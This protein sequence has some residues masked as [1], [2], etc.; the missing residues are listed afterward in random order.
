[1]DPNGPFGAKEAGEGSMTSFLP[2]LANAVYRATGVRMKELP[3]TPD[4]LLA[5]QGK[6]EKQ[7]A[8]DAAAGGA[9]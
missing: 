7:Q 9:E 1:M 4:R 5:A 2:A 3:I 6:L 8:R